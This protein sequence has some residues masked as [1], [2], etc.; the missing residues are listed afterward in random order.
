MSK[1]LGTGIDP[2]A[3]IDKHGADA[4]R[5][6]LLAMGSSQ[7]VRYSDEKIRQGQDLANKL[8][9]AARF[10]IL[11]IEPGVVAEAR[12][13]AIEDRWIL[14]RLER[15]E[16][17]LDERFA[18]YD[19]PHAA[20]DLYGFVYGELCDWY[21]EL[22][23]PRF[24]GEQRLELSSTLRF[25]LRET[26]ALAH[27]L[28]PFVTEEMWSYVREDGE[29]LLAGHLRTPLPV[30]LRDPEAESAIERMIAATQAVRSWRDSVNVK[31]GAPVVAR[32]QATGYEGI[33]HLIA[34]QARLELRERSSNGSEPQASVAIPGGSIAILEGIDTEAQEA[35]AAKR[36]EALRT[37]IARA[38]AKLDNAAF[39]ANAPAEIIAKE[40]QKLDQL[41]EELRQG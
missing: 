10:A 22:V 26:L 40:Q 11:S 30:A 33:A 15:I 31:P 19:F 36:R 1:S 8:F 39:I 17:A 38:N 16:R 23:K 32:I 35:R 12:P 21:I 28:I 13:S 20:L 3:E 4:V 34:Q 18:S 27:P 6:G 24:S 5:F 2:L 25:V 41:E 9:N 14:S 29:G 37:E 7:D